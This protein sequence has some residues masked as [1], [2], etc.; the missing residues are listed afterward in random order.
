AAQ[1][2]LSDLGVVDV[3]IVGLAKRLEEVWLPGEE[4]P[5]VLPR[6]SEGLYLLQ[7]VRD[8]A[9]R[10]AITHHRKRRAKRM[11][12]SELE[13]IP[14]LGRGRQSTLLRAFGSVRNLRAATVEEV[15]AV[16]GIGPKVAQSVVAAL[17]GAP[18]KDRAEA[19]AGTV[20][21][22]DHD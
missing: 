2:A 8:E 7:R 1:R 12:R 17:G 16:P 13:G 19:A 4:F 21:S 5:L 6:T 11:T 20:P 9:H 15:A 22:S 18:E 14:G 3:A 10:F